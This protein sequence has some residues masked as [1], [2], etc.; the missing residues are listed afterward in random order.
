MGD[1][2][3]LALSFVFIGVCSAFFGAVSGI[4]AALLSVIH[5]TVSVTGLP[6]S[7]SELFR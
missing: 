5:K 1:K 3:I 6:T 7:H 4:A 2:D